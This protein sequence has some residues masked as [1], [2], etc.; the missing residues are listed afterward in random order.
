MSFLGIK[1]IIVQISTE[2]GLRVFFW[3]Q[4]QTGRKEKVT[5]SFILFRI[6]VLGNFHDYSLILLFVTMFK[7]GPVYGV[8]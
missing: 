6:T 4:P 2:I 3:I 8:C 7:L 1:V 5:T